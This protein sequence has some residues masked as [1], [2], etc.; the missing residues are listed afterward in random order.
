MKVTFSLFIC[1]LCFSYSQPAFA[2]VEPFGLAGMKITAFRSGY[3]IIVAGTGASGVFKIPENGDNPNWEYL[4]LEGIY[5]KD[6]YPHDLGPVPTNPQIGIAASNQDDSVFVYC[7]C[8]DNLKA[9]SHGISFPI[10][11]IDGYPS[12]AICGETFALGDIRT[13]YH[14]DR[15]IQSGAFKSGFC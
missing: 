12:I 2:Q 15:A 1:C 4:G 7:W 10:H 11:S 13:D 14:C 3:G 6:V 9:N 8:V 5:V